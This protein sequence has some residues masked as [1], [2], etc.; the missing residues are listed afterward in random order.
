MH[1]PKHVSLCQVSFDDI[2]MR[3]VIMW[4]VCPGA[5]GREQCGGVCGGPD[6]AAAQRAG[7]ALGTS[8]DRRAVASHGRAGDRK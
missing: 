8:V 1:T 2:E 6:T 3:I 7:R 5:G 4:Q